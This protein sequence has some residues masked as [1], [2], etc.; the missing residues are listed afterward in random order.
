[1]YIGKPLMQM[2]AADIMS[3]PNFMAQ[4]PPGELP[5]EFRCPVCRAWLRGYDPLYVQYGG[6][7]GCEHCIEQSSPW[8]EYE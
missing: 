6:V 4:E 1:M 7:I 8:E 5:A 2:S 3:V